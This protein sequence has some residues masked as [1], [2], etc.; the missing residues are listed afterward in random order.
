MRHQVADKPMVSHRLVRMSFRPHLA[1]PLGRA[2]QRA[3]ARC[4]GAS[5]PS[6]ATPSAVVFR[7][8]PSPQVIFLVLASA[9]YVPVFIQAV[10]AFLFLLHCHTPKFG[11]TLFYEGPRG[12]LPL[13]DGGS[14]G[15]LACRP[16][17]THLAAPVALLPRV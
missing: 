2:G 15:G 17:V 13:P 12:G 10:Y 1:G 6:R 8:L 11:H 14:V 5:L 16:Y 3:W 9:P 4:P 7:R